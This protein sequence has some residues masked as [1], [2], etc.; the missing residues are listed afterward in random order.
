[1][2]EQKYLKLLKEVLEF[3]SLSSNR[4]NIKTLSIIGSQI[5]YNLENQFPLFT[6]KKIHWK[7]IVHELLWFIK[8]D[9]NIKYLNDNG[10][11]I[12]N[13]WADDDGDL[14]PI[15]GHQWRKYMSPHTYKPI[16]QLQ[17][18]IN[19]IKSNPDSRRLIVCSWNP[20]DLQYM[21]LPPCHCL[22]QFHVQ[23]DKISC[24]LY[25]RSADLFLGVPFNV[26]SYSL[27]TYMIAHECNLKPKEF[28]HTISDAHIYVN[29]IDQVKK[30]LSRKPS[31]ILP[32]LSL[33]PFKKSIFDIVFDDI[34]LSNYSPQPVIKGKVAI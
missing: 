10:V 32:K 3:G 27:L 7:S 26:A 8:G 14:G 34:H 29:H 22:F 23:N 18:I 24:H 16:D 31:H 5:K 6:T 1:M 19:E 30:Q 13:E 33:N 11:R 4:T 25:Q 9:T 2:S 28:I 20:A 21:A 17:N 15:Y 12:W